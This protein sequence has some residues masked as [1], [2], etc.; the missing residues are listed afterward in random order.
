MDIVLHIGAHRTATTSFQRWLEGQGG[1]VTGGL[2]VWGP[3]VTRGARF[4]GLV[5]AP[6]AVTAP[7]VTLAAHSTGAI[8]LEMLRM[9]RAGARLLL[10]SEENMPGSMRE[11]F[12]RAALYPMAIER[13]A[14]FRPAFRGR[15]VRIGFGIRAQ[16]DYWAS[17]LG[18]ALQA[19]LPL[20]GPHAFARIAASRRG[21][22][23]VIA[24]IAESFPQAE[25]MVWRYEDLGRHPQDLFA[26]LTGMAPIPGPR[27]AR[28]NASPGPARLAALIASRGAP[29]LWLSPRARGLTPF[30]PE[31]AAALAEA[32]VA[33]LAW[34][35]SGAGGLARWIG[36]GGGRRNDIE[37]GATPAATQDTGRSQEGEGHGRSARRMGRAGPQGT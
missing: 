22:R 24:D 8:R 21:W 27:A 7:V 5:K 31:Q 1:D 33:D 36:A 32:D 19:G 9:A 26:A 4:D 10:V 18:Y 35:A 20:P 14:R 16:A 34:L 13:L 25:I 28:H 6:G 12:A 11:N 3:Q 30:L 23:H 29:A 37:A 2:A 17:A 15:A